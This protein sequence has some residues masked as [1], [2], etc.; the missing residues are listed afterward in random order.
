MDERIKNS[1]NNNTDEYYQS[2]IPFYEEIIKNPERAFPI[3]VYPLIKK[4]IG[5]LKGK[6]ICVPSSGDNI[7]AYKDDLKL[8]ALLLDS[9]PKPSE[10][11]E[12]EMK[13]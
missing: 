8:Y 4:Y 3:A 10:V 6:K 12:W 13:K 9:Q 1:W 5:D 2:T 7:A 11:V